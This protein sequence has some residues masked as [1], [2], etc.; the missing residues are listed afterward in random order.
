MMRCVALRLGSRAQEGAGTSVDI[1]AVVGM[2]VSV[3]NERSE[4]R[5]TVLPGDYR[6]VCGSFSTRRGPWSKTG[7]GLLLHGSVARSSTRYSAALGS[8]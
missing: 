1:R 4:G 7:G 5:M 2:V 8:P 3:L 6:S